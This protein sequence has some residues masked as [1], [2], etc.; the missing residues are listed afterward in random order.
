[1]KKTARLFTLLILMQ[2]CIGFTSTS[3][4]VAQDSDVSLIQKLDLES[5]ENG[6]IHRFNLQIGVNHFS[7]AI[8]I[9]VIVIK[10]K[11]VTPT[12]GLTAA[13]H[14]NELNGIGIIHRLVEEIEATNLN[15]S[16][17][18]IPGLNPQAIALQQRTHPEGED[19]NRIFPGKKTGNEASQLTY[20]I[21]Q[22]LLPSFTHLIDMHTASFGR[23][24]SFYV[25]ATLGDSTMYKMAYA[26]QADIVLNSAGAPSAG[27][28]AS[29]LTLRAMAMSMGIPS[30]T[31]EYGNPQV[32]QKE[33]ISRGL[34]G[35]M[36]TLS[37][38]DMIQQEAV[39]TDL[40][41]VT[42]ASS[43]WIYTDTGGYLEIPVELNEQ[44]DKGDIIGKIRDPYGHILKTYLAPESGIVIGKS[45]NPVNSAGGRIIHLG[46]LANSPQ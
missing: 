37:V 3:Y 13:I 24:N 32:Y 14:G 28:K 16:I 18:A 6:K 7:E 31:V 29:G 27:A 4:V 12:L 44:V 19:L 1:M 35:L 21:T 10:G 5:L 26:Q 42:C 41:T 38:L 36:N 9:P 17:I 2:I 39:T 23:E 22:K 11:A 43:Y 46:I 15:G 34:N 8:S 25:R 30:I 33:M 20:E 40:K 45:S